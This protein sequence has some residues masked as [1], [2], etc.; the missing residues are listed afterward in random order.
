MPIHLYYL[1]LLKSPR[2]RYYHEECNGKCSIS[3]GVGNWLS[4]K[5]I[6]ALI[7]LLM[8]QTCE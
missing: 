7:D 8:C 2:T 4:L 5:G 1:D 3:G 6:D